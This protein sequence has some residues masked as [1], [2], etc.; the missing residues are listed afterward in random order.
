MKIKSVYLDNIRL[1]HDF[2][3]SC[4][5]HNNDEFYNVVLIVGENGKGKSTFLEAI[6][7]C[8][9]MNNSLYGG[10]IFNDND[11]S[12][13]M[14][15]GTIIVD[16]K[17]NEKEIEYLK[18]SINRYDF[19]QYIVKKDRAVKEN[20]ELQKTNSWSLYN[21]DGK[22]IG[23]NNVKLPLFFDGKPSN[24]F[25]IL[26]FDV[27][28]IIPKIPINGPDYSNL[29]KSPIEKSLS[30]S[31]QH[32]NINERF[33]ITKQWLVNLDYKEAK[34]HQD[35]GQNT[36]LMREVIDAFNILFAPYTFSK[37]THKSH[38]MFKTPDGDVDIDN[39]SDG[40]K[41]VFSII[42]E[43]LF[44]FSLPY[45]DQDNIDIKSI[46]NTEAIVL[47]DE[48]DCH[49]HPKWQKNIIPALRR[50]FPNVQFI[51]TTHSPFVVSSVYPD[52]V[53][54]LGEV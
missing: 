34:L 40:L 22:R 49:L 47:I 48:I 7:S 24:N 53:Y 30:S 37:I 46:L 16:T 27:F 5:D 52:E 17:M 9:T 20:Q 31:I 41:S 23:N 14:D 19:F 13:N 21:R 33:Q 50:L 15:I 54:K 8:F 2:N 3:L 45:M 12:N 35:T 42:G 38:I 51:I 26:Y 36:G 25:L 10:N 44:R 4:I 11:I 28:R 39:L 18:N 6:V 43:M 1:F 29:P 32:Q